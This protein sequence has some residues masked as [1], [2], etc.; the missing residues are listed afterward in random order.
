MDKNLKHNNTKNIFIKKS[1][2]SIVKNKKTLTTRKLSKFSVR[3][4][5]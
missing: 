5:Y 3:I 1:Y 2:N 4:N